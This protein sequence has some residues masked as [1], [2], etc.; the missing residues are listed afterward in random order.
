MVRFQL[1]VAKLNKEREGGD[2]FELATFP[3]EGGSP[4]T[5]E[6]ALLDIKEKGWKTVVVAVD[7]VD[8]WE[9]VYAQVDKQGMAPGEHGYVWY[10]FDTTDLDMLT[11]DAADWV[12]NPLG[13]APWMPAARARLLH[14][15]GYFRVL[16]GFEDDTGP[17]RGPEEGGDCW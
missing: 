4:D 3:V 9:M 16:N 15:A 17:C 13:K 2:K 12:P 8:Q 7:R 6:R 1:A 14:G 11:V 10:S 5:Y